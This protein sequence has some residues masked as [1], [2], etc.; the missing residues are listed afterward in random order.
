MKTE[1]EL[2]KSLNKIKELEVE[3]RTMYKS[4]I[5]HIS[6][7]PIDKVYSVN[8]AIMVTLQFVLD[9]EVEEVDKTLIDFLE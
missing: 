5:S 2:E 6:D 8:R 4:G 3:L 1:E 7:Q 9:K